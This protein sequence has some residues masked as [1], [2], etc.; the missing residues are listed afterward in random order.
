MGLDRGLTL[1]LTVARLS[2]DRRL[3]VVPPQEK[4]CKGMKNIWNMQIKMKNG[5][6]NATE[7]HKKAPNSIRQNEQSPNKIAGKGRRR[8]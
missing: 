3:T 7:M 1:A 4:R 8:G 5:R 6:K 2:L